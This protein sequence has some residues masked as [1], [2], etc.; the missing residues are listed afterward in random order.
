MRASIKSGFFAVA[1]GLLVFSLHANAADASKEKS[2]N[3]KDD[4]YAQCKADC[5]PLKKDSE[6]FESCMIKCWKDYG[7]K[8]TPTPK[9]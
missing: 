5:K 4:P 1:A 7:E 6:A 3:H 9:K 2:N 8:T